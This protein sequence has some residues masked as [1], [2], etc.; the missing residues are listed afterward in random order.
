MASVPVERVGCAT[1]WTT[2]ALIDALWPIPLSP[3]SEIILALFCHCIRLTD[4]SKG[5][6]WYRVAPH[7]GI[8]TAEPPSRSRYVTISPSKGLIYYLY[9]KL[10]ICSLPVPL[11]P[12]LTFKSISH[13][14]AWSLFSD[15]CL[16]LLQLLIH[17]FVLWGPDNKVWSVLVHAVTYTRRYA[18]R[19]KVTF[20]RTLL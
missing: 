12:Y 5:T 11:M 2:R 1:K 7:K 20:V 6:A 13:C 3:L 14:S 9:Q 16:Y 18:A 17:F 19:L 4:L 8:P 15:G 10:T